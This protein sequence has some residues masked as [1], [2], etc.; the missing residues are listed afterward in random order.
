MDLK[1]SNKVNNESSLTI[2]KK[3]LLHQ[4]APKSVDTA[5]KRAFYYNLNYIIRSITAFAVFSLLALDSLLVN[6]KYSV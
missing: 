3:I 1:G 4:H 6:L 5:L 2:A